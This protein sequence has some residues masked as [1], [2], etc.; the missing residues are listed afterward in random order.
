MSL[1]AASSGLEWSSGFIFHVLLLSRVK[2]IASGGRGWV[3]A[4]TA[5]TPSVALQRRIAQSSSVEGT[6]LPAS[7]QLLSSAD[8]P[9]GRRLGIAPCGPV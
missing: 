1:Q 9:G 2:V 7:P 3:G 8:G 4:Q 6:P 5:C